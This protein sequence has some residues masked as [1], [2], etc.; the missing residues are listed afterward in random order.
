MKH[1]SGPA[2]ACALGISFTATCGA[3]NADPFPQVRYEISGSGVA[4]YISYQT[5]TGQQRA[6]N[7][8]LPWST[9]FT[10]FGGQVFVLS[11]QGPG[12]ITCRILV[13]GEVVT[14]QTATGAPGHTVCTH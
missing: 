12:S 10:G 3:A 6:V 9:Q 13:N 2:V 7:V 8:G 11:A 4:E 5:N 1:V 14:Q